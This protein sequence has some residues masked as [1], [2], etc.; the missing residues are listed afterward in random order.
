MHRSAPDRRASKGLGWSR[1]WSCTLV[2]PGTGDS[3]PAREINVG[4]RADPRPLRRQRRWAMELAQDRPETRR[5]DE[6]WN[7]G[8]DDAF[9]LSAAAGQ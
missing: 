3:G 2:G 8:L 1:P 9:Q 4:T 6:R 5:N 7:D